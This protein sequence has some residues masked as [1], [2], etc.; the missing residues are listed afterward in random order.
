MEMLD[1]VA[2]QFAERLMQGVADHAAKHRR[3]IKSTAQAVDIMREIA[4]AFLYGEDWAVE[5]DCLLANRGSEATIW[6]S[7]ILACV[8]KIEWRD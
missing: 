4:K 3:E 2:K 7:V 5:R 1:A 6:P 8:A